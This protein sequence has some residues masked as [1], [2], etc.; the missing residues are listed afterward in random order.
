MPVGVLAS[1][2]IPAINDTEIERI[3]EA[4]GAAGARTAGYVLLRLPWEVKDLFREWL[5]DHYPLKAARVL[6]LLRQCREGRLNDPS[7]GG[8][9]RGQGAYAD[10]IRRRFEAARRRFGLDG[11]LPELDVTRFRVPR[12]PSAQGSLFPGD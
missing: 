8:R 5:R 12:A 11:S 10:L 1:P 3:L 4:S 7:F 9:M 6:S 2:M